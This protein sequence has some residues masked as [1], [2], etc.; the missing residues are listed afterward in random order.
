MGLEKRGIFLE[1]GQCQLSL[2]FLKGAL[3]LKEGLGRSRILSSLY[4]SGLRNK[5][6]DGL[7]HLT[8]TEHG[9]EEECYRSSD[10]VFNQRYSNTG[11][12]TCALA[13]N[14][15]LRLDNFITSPWLDMLYQKVLETPPCHYLI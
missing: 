9:S 15:S 5:R 7:R 12:L 8:S 10:C 4:F 11:R 1:F 13:I 14:C 3:Y 6:V 2:W